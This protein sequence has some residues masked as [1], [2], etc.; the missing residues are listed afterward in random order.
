MSRWFAFGL[1][2]VVAALVVSHV[3]QPLSGAG[4]PLR[5][6]EHYVRL[7]S[8]APAIT[9]QMAHLY[10]RERMTDDVLRS[11][12][13]GD[14]VVL[15]VHGAGTPAE[16]AFDVPYGDYSWMGYLARAGFDV[17]AM[18]M[19]GYG[20]STKPSPMDDPCN[21]TREQQMSSVARMLAAPCAPSYTGDVSTIRSDW[22]DIN[23]VV[24]HIRALR[25]V[26]K[27]SLV[28]WSQGGAR[29]GGFTVKHP[30]K[31]NRLVVLAPMSIVAAAPAGSAP[32]N[33]AGIVSSTA[34][35][36]GAPFSTQSHAEFTANW[37]RQV[38][39]PAQYDPVVSDAIWQDMQASDPVGA[40]W[41]PGVRRASNARRGAGDWDATAAANL[42]VPTL[43][44]SG[45]HD[46]QVDPASVRQLHAA[47][48]ATDKVFIDLGCSSHNAMWEKNHLELFEASRQWLA[49]GAVN[50]TK[51]GTL[52]LGYG[53]S[54]R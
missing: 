48:G 53:T 20:R 26:D 17:F 38:G 2:L 33:A 25:H 37:N 22:D 10:V 45:V 46:K 44:V 27:V 32:G 8:T 40:T 6:V 29:A 13:L 1:S 39:C 47:L 15:M 28:A 11:A 24:D 42:K 19:T 41:G 21:L 49:T 52:R 12:N 5:T 50:G 31:V 16:V 35:A 18:D 54:E 3:V 51:S 34:A 23:A 30:E 36:A 43:L 9:G 7:K 14:R 4:E